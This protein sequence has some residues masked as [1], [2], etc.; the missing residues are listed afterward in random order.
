MIQLR[1]GG[2]KLEPGGRVV[3]VATSLDASVP[4]VAVME[5]QAARTLP[6]P[7]LKAGEGSAALHV[8]V[9]R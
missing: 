2:A 4:G 7:S 9:A 3:S 5:N 1:Q 8:R 6:A